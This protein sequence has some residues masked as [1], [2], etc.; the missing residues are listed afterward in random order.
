MNEEVIDLI[1]D[2][3]WVKQC[4]MIG[5]RLMLAQMKSQ[6]QQL[7]IRL[8]GS[9]C[10]NITPCAYFQFLL[11]FRSQEFDSD[12][13]AEEAVRRM[14]WIDFLRATTDRLEDE[15]KKKEMALLALE[16]KEK[17][18]S[19]LYDDISKPVG[20]DR[21]ADLNHCVARIEFL[22]V[23]LEQGKM[24][25]KHQE[26]EQFETTQICKTHLQEMSRIVADANSYVQFIRSQWTEV[27]QHTRRLEIERNCFKDF[28]YR[29]RKQMI[30]RMNHRRMFHQQIKNEVESMDFS[31]K[32]RDAAILERSRKSESF[33]EESQKRISGTNGANVKLLTFFQGEMDASLI[34]SL[35]RSL[36]VACDFPNTFRLLK[37][38]FVSV[39]N[40]PRGHFLTL[41]TGFD[42]MMVSMEQ[43]QIFFS[44]QIYFF[45]LR[46]LLA[47]K[48]YL[49][50]LSM[51][52]RR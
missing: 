42:W 11:T 12:D 52:S 25:L 10:A 40:P 1:A 41:K 39:S 44:L 5:I 26:S 33:T 24:T 49:F 7:P 28:F 35:P 17:E 29:N 46:P 45:V 8:P 30:D 50:L 48:I 36:S 31:A 51:S 14:K 47:L 6:F 19:E 3:A 38:S 34:P 32:H 9:S 20:M 37:G 23:Q 22:N 2:S 21:I 16:L 43:T 27:V 18:T 4:W 13:L 15:R